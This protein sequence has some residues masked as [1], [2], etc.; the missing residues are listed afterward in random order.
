M[1]GATGKRRHGETAGIG[2]QVKHAQTPRLLLYPAP[3]ITHIE[4]Q[5]IVL[6][7]AQI[8]LVTQAILADDPFFDRLAQQSLHAAVW[9]IAML[10]QQAVRPACLPPGT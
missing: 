1:L 3:A 4:K 2:K 6:L 5:A 7:D 8:K 10:Q 9:Q